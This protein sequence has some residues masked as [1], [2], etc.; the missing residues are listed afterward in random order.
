ML[1]DETIYALATVGG[2]SAIATFRISGKNTRKI[3]KKISL[4]KQI[5]SKNAKLTK[6]F[7]NKKKNEEVDIGT[8]IFYKSPKS[9]TGEDLAEI[10]VHGSPA[11]IKEM[12]GILY[13]TGLCRLAYPG[14]FTRRAFENNKIDLIQAE[15]VIDLINAETKEQRIQASKQLSGKF[16]NK[17]NNINNAIKRI[18]ANQEAMIDFSEE[19]IPNNLDTTNIEQI[20]NIINEI[21]DMLDDRNI[22][23]N[24][25]DGFAIS[26]LG[27]PNTG[28]SSLINYLANRE[29]AIVTAKPGTTTDIIELRYDLRGLPVVFY[30]TAGLRKSSNKIEKIGINKAIKRST[31]SSANLVIINKKEEIK[32]YKKKFKNIIFIQ[33]KI[34]IS[35]KLII[36]NDILH[37]SSKTGR[38][39]KILLEK[40]HKKIYLEPEK[41][42]SVFVSRE[43]HR[44]I[45]INVRESLMQ[46]LKIEQIDI[47]AE[48]IRNAMKG[49]SKITGNNSIDEILD[50]IFNDF[51]I[52]K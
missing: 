40:I 26:I 34:D 48:E 24:I 27:K 28:K 46:S 16:G 2:K 43:R 15:A 19:E 17:I 49:L 39:I 25:R 33:S 1:T 13:N 22:G 10:T 47:K 36:S 23:E 32:A 52:G 31:K 42:D 50:I 11:I 6:I 7:T 9:Y 14:E 38:G 45:L 37:I 21:S 41:R 12:Y 29:L 20:K 3:I 35:K 8:I 51:C 18:L 44:Q 4:I 5:E 30:D